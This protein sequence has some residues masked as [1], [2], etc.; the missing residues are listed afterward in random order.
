MT[1][2]AARLTQCGR[3]GEAEHAA[4]HIPAHTVCAAVHAVASNGAGEA[5]GVISAWHESRAPCV[6]RGHD[7]GY[8]ENDTGLWLAVLR[9][10]EG[11]GDRVASE[12]LDSIVGVSS[13]RRP[14]VVGQRAFI[15]GNI[16]DVVEVNHAMTGEHKAQCAAAQQSSSEEDGD[17][18]DG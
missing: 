14:L 11:R 1:V 4:K 12:A 16:G 17:D 13:A 5:M 15:L 7:V 6:L 18:A 10:E 2:F 8:R 9:A 3:V